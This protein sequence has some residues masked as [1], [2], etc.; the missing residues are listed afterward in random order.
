MSRREQVSPES[1]PPLTVEQR[2]G[3]ALAAVGCCYR[4]SLI[5]DQPDAIPGFIDRE[6]FLPLVRLCTRT[7]EAHLLA[8]QAALTP[9]C[10]A[11][12]AADA[13]NAGGRP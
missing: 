13:P 3:Y 5:A 12:E 9:S 11:L 2:I 1:H 4:A 10:F 7:A 6:T 8:V